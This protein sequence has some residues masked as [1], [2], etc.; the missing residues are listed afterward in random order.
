MQFDIRSIY[1]PRSTYF[2]LCYYYLRCD[3]LNCI[4]EEADSGSQHY[5]QQLQFPYRTLDYKPT[6]EEEEAEAP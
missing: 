4:Q 2:Q 5:F 1:N 6:S 3:M